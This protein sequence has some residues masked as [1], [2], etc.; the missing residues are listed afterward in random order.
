MLSGNPMCGGRLIVMGGGKDFW[1]RFGEW[2]G[3]TGH[4]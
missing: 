2:T 1:E 3:M 4:T